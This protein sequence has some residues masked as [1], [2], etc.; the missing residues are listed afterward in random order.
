[1]FGITQQRKILTLEA[2]NPQKCNSRRTVW[3][4]LTILWEMMLKG[5]RLNKHMNNEH[6]S[7]AQLKKIAKLFLKI[8][9]CSYRKIFKVCLAVFQ[10]Y[11]WKR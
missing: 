10:Y 4:C 2:P 6:M 7:H 8:L 3:M 9:C 11:A 5:L 1:M